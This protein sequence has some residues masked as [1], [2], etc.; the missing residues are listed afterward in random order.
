MKIFLVTLNA[1][2]FLFFLT[3]GAMT[4]SSRK[5]AYFQ[6]LAVFLASLILCT[7]YVMNIMIDLGLIK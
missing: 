2:A 7:M 1:A 4:V 6:R 3:V 5:L